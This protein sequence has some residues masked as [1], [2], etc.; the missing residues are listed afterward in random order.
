M[1]K[2]SNNLQNAIN[3]IKSSIEEA[4]LKSGTIG[5]NNL[6]RTSKPIKL[7]HNIIKSELKNQNINPDLIKPSINKS[8]GELKLSG[9][10]K[11]KSQDVCVIP[12]NI[13][14][15]EEILDFKGILYK[16]KD[17]FGFK[18]T[19]KTLSINV[20]SQLSSTAKNFDTLYERTFAEALNLHLRCP[21]MVLGEFYMI[22]VRE[23]NSD[24]TNKKK[25]EYKDIKGIKKHIEKYLLSFDALNQRISYEK[26][27]F[28]YEKVC[29]LIVDFSKEIP[30]I[31]NSDKELKKDGLLDNNSI[32]TI[33]N[34]SFESFIKDL[35]IIYTDRFGKGI[36]S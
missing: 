20:R 30:K 13:D 8:N 12:N 16:Q 5:K 28:K 18:F 7:L 24:Q 22:I 15:S 25:I 1:M 11:K 19:E 31:Y 26:D 33:K 4:I 23:F 27:F 34:L 29:L 17:K 3:E 21:K 10:F 32:A 9:F 35:L 2:V 6:I 36:L 14:P